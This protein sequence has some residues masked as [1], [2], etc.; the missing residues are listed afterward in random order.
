M[1]GLEADP[2]PGGEDGKE[3]AAGRGHI[4]TQGDGIGEIAL[5]EAVD[6]AGDEA[7]WNR[8]DGDRCKQTNFFGISISAQ[9]S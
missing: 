2:A 4:A 9:T 5:D 1:R 7:D 6:Q 8:E 3:E